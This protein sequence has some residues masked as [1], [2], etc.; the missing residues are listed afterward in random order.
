MHPYGQAALQPWAAPLERRAATVKSS[1][2]QSNA[3][4]FKAVR[5]LISNLRAAGQ[6]QSAARLT[7]GLGCINGLTDEWALFLESIESVQEAHG[8]AFANEDRE[9]LEGIREAAHRAV[10]R[11]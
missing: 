4:L 11:R 2:F 5:E 8:A 10:H 3:A 7:E 1:R 9:T 6:A